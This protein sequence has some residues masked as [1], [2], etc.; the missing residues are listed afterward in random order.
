ML[1]LQYSL[2]LLLSLSVF[3][4]WIIGSD[5][6]TEEL[7]Y[8]LRAILRVIAGLSL[9]LVWLTLPPLR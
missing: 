3:L 8:A 6:L 4:D 7:D 1:P 2:L 9:A 5:N